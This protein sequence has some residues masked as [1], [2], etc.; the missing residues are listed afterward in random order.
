MVST[1]VHFVTLLL[2]IKDLEMGSFDSK[3]YVKK[4]SGRNKGTSM[5]L[6]GRYCNGLIVFQMVEVVFSCCSNLMVSQLLVE[7]LTLHHRC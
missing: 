4:P 3:I 1:V 6:G 7:A 5:F 2:Y